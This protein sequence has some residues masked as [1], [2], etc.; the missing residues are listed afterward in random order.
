VPF[1]RDLGKEIA[2]DEEIEEV[3]DEDR[4]HQRKGDPI[5]AVERRAVEQR[6]QIFGS[7]SRHPFL[8]RALLRRPRL[9][10]ADE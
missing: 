8:P 10:F 7:L 6:Q 3:V 2:D 4:R 5:A 9:L 1:G